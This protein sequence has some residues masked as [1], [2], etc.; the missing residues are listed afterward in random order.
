MNVLDANDNAPIFERSHYEVNVTS[1]PGRRAALITVKASD[2]DA[3]EN[4]EIIYRLSNDPQNQF[5]IDEHNGTIFAKVIG[6]LF[7]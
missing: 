7:L 6:S 4:A 2:S 5:E 1:H 3:G